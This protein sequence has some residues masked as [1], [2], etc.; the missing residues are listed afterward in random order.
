MADEGELTAREWLDSVRRGWGAKVGPCTSSRRHAGRTH[1]DTPHTD[2]LVHPDAT[3]S[4]W[5][6]P[7]SRYRLNPRMAVCRRVRGARLRHFP[8]GL[9]GGRRKRPGRPSHGAGQSRREAAARQEDPPRHRTPARACRCCCCPRRRP[10]G[11][12]SCRDQGTRDHAQRRCSRRGGRPRPARRWPAG[13]DGQ[14]LHGLPVAQQ[15]AGGHGGSCDAPNYRSLTA[16]ALSLS[17]SLPES[18]PG[19]SVS[20]LG[21]AL[22]FPASSRLVQARF[23]KQSLETLLGPGH[24]IFLDS[25]GPLI[26]APL[27][28][29]LSSRLTDLP[30]PAPRCPHTPLCRFPSPIL[31]TCRTCACS[32]STS[33]TRRC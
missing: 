9:P 17:L 10:R 16:S 19:L 15:E 13:A 30:L 11:R 3:P 26:L 18:Y 23:V 33:R 2:P 14:A 6:P 31:Q 25:D 22:G 1:A 24:D 28:P 12:P 20:P 29:R 21:F 7:P 4:T 32:W 8:G 27:I 5:L